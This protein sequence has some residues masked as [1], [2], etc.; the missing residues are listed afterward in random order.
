MLSEGIVKRGLLVFPGRGAYTSASLGTLDPGHPLVR[1]AEELR[2]GYD[3]PPLLD[4]DGAER[5]DPRVHLAP[6]NASPLIFLVSLVDAGTIDDE[7]RPIVAVGNSLGWY[8]ALVAAGAL[9]FDDGYR[10]VQEMSLLQQEPLPEGGPGGQVIYPLTDAEWRP[11]PALE[12]TVLAAVRPADGPDPEVFPSIDLGGYAVLAGTEAG[13]ARLIERLPPLRLGERLYP[14]RLALHGPYHTPLVRHVAAAAQE[15]LA[16]LD[17]Q[18]PRIALVDG[19][20]ATWSPWSTD[21]VALRDYTLGEQVVTPFDFAGAVRVAVR[22]W[23]PDLL[24]LP[25]PGNSLGGIAG[26][27]LVSEGYRGI[28]GRDDFERVQGNETLVLS[29]RR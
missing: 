1:R 5:F 9:G 4:L 27:I 24:V 16:G 6:A 10:L 19:R 23:A 15:R 17:W 18:P 2:A 3:L 25:G 12:A 26:R 13:M 22:E 20:G 21:P 29:M 28:H 8:T 7:I 11:D 14:L